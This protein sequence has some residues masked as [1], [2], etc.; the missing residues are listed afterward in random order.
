MYYV[1]IIQNETIPAIFGYNSFE[2]ANAKFHSELAYRAVGRTSTHCAIMT[3]DLSFI[4]S[5]SYTAPVSEPNAEPTEG[6]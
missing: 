6:E 4:K 2:E 3:A 5:E 1:V